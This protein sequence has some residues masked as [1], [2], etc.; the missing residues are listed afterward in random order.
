M[1]KSRK[2]SKI[3]QNIEVIIFVILII[4]T[5]G[6]L[7]LSYFVYSIFQNSPANFTYFNIN[8]NSNEDFEIYGFSGSGTEID[9]YIIENY[10]FFTDDLYGIS[11]SGVDKHF[12]IRNNIIFNTNGPGISIYDVGDNFTRIIN[13]TILGYAFQSDFEEGIRITLTNGCV[14]ANNTVQNKQEG[15]VIRASN[16]C[17]IMQNELLYNRRNIEIRDS[18]STHVENNHFKTFEGQLYYHEYSSLYILDSTNTTVENNVFIG[19][20]MWISYSSFSVLSS[21][22]LANNSLNGEKLSYFQNQNDLTFNNA[23]PHE[24]IILYNCSN[25]RIDGLS[26]TKTNFA[27]Y[28]INCSHV[29]VTNCQFNNILYR[30]LDTSNCSNLLLKDCIFDSCNI[31][32]RLYHVDPGF[33]DN[34][35]FTN[36]IYGIIE[37]SF[38]SITYQNN[39]FTNNSYDIA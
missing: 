6:I 18:N 30:G 17:I 12:I 11:I 16:N 37:G 13:N 25:I 14:I 32:I 5:T 38:S 8:I 10:T 29:N 35:S 7:Y 1:M 36:N 21:L 24:Q 39:T 23:D 22:R 20:G 2:N 26:F 33:I 9:P 19:W 15:I 27:L 3:R 4:I 28:L 31:G 34:N